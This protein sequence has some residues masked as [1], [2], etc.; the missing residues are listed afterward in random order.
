MGDKLGPAPTANGRSRMIKGFAA[1][2]SPRNAADATVA[3]VCGTICLSESFEV[4]PDETIRAI[5]EKRF[6]IVAKPRVRLYEPGRQ[7]G[8]VGEDKLNRG[9]HNVV[10][11]HRKPHAPT[12]VIV[13]ILP[14]FF[15]SFDVRYANR[16]R[17]PK[18]LSNAEFRTGRQ[19]PQPG[20]RRAFY[21][22]RRWRAPRAPTA[23]QSPQVSPESQ[24]NDSTAR[25]TR[26][27]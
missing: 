16:A 23:Q 3:T 21:R 7:S 4:S 17:V 22:A 19:A 18:A 11:D 1:R 24:T 5:R 8:R 6:G 26:L 20:V 12:E 14:D 27:D 9:R 15:L 13:A 25:P 10:S 2:G